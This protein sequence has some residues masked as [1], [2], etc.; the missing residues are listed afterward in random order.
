MRVRHGE[1]FVTRKIT[2]AIEPS[3]N[4][5]YLG[6][7]DAMRDWGHAR[8]YTEGMWM[9]LQQQEP[10]DYV[11]AT[12]EQHSVREFI[13]KAFAHVGRHIEWRGSGADEKGID[14][15]SGQVLIEVD[16]RYFRPTEVDLLVG[17]P[18]KAR[19]GLGWRHKTGFDELVKEMVEADLVAVRREK[20]RKNRHD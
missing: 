17:D 11:L 19:H 5:L 9:I 3:C 2:R 8:D 20:E 7:L 15:R 1:T 18:S 10:D 12:G 13:E 6:N 4:K 14:A 16:A